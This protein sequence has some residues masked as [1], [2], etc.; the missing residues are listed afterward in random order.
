MKKQNKTEKNIDI[1]LGVIFVSVHITWISDDNIGHMT[2]LLVS[3]TGSDKSPP[4]GHKRDYIELPNQSKKI[5]LRNKPTNKSTTIQFL[6][7]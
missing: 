3:S 5:Y 4:C 2:P 1:H 7:K 6:Q